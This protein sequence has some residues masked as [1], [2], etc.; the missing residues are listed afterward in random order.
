[1]LY[2]LFLSLSHLNIYPVLFSMLIISMINGMLEVAVNLDLLRRLRY[3]FY[4]ILIILFYTSFYLLLSNIPLET[5]RK[6]LLRTDS[7]QLS[8]QIEVNKSC[9]LYRYS[10][11]III[12]ITFM[13]IIQ[14]DMDKI[15]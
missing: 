4:K 14:K 2:R 3:F 7:L 6:L 5:I 8:K 13:R 10:Q 12:K 11:D 15:N 1:M 9:K